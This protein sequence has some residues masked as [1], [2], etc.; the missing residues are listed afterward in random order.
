MRKSPDGT[1]PVIEL[2]TIKSSCAS[3]ALADLCLPASIGKPGLERLDQ[4]I[5]KRK[6][7]PRGEILYAAGSTHVSLYV[8]RAGSFKT[9]VDMPDGEGQILG[10]HFPGELLGLDAL[11]SDMHR[12]HAQALER[13]SVCE[14]PFQDIIR[15]AAQ[16]PELQQQLYKVVSEEFIREHSH[17]V[18]M[19]RQ[20]ASSRLALFL[21]GLSERRSLLQLDP[22]EITLS[23]SR[24]DMANYLGLVIETISRLLSRF[25]D[26][27]V[28]EVD[29]RLI[30]IRDA[31]A[32]KALA[33]NEAPLPSRGVARV[34]RPG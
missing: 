8:V 20:A 11:P 13:S 21:H 31:H 4:L 23:M 28:I 25:Q 14:V 34:V 17:V 19:G 6:P 18:M 30:R 16:I 10:F 29:R 27:G 24:Q 3:C 26:M 1:M 22:L 9:Y 12:C 2:E 7:V 5:Q 15:L 33:R 32:L